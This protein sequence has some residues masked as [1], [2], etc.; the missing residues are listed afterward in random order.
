MIAGIEDRLRLLEDERD[1]QRTLYTYG[2]ALD[3]GYEAEFVDCWTEDAELFWPASGIIKGRAAIQAAFR[4]HTH[5][6]AAVHKHLVIDPFI[7]IEGDRARVDSMFARL[8]PY[9][10]VPEIRAFGRYRDVLVRCADGRWRFVERLA[11]LEA[12][13]PGGQTE[14]LSQPTVGRSLENR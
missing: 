9:D 2:H 13:R 14:G 10:D 5:A 8:D 11:E 12:K 1:I 3:Y 7:K 4:R 6:P